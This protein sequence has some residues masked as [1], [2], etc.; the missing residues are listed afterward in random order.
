M[1]RQL[2]L[3]DGRI[4]AKR[5]A[6]ERGLLVESRTIGTDMAYNLEADNLSRSGFLL[7]SAG[8]FKVPFQINTILEL[9]VDTRGKFFREPISCLAKIVRIEDTTVDG[10]DAVVQR[11][12]GVSIVQME[13]PYTEAWDRTLAQLERE[14]PETNITTMAA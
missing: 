9:R 12:Y 1:S 14:L 4:R 5:I 7:N 13:P 2:R 3:P 8:Y 11:R 10:D 6:S